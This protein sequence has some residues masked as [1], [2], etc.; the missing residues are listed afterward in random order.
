MMNRYD[1]DL[2]SLAAPGE[3]LFR[4]ENVPIVEAPLA[5][6]GIEGLV[7]R[8]VLSRCRFVYDGP[9]STFSLSF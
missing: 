5:A 2:Q 9:T 8:D 7:G 1:V 3:L 6:Q 4:L